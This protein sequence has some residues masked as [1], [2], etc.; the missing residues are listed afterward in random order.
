MF[1]GLGLR[2]GGLTRVANNTL[3]GEWENQSRIFW[4]DITTLWE[5]LTT[6]IGTFK[7]W[8]EQTKEYWQL[9]NTIDWNNW[10]ETQGSLAMIEENTL[11]NWDAI[12]I[13]WEN[14][15]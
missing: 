5:T 4:E 2:L 8:N 13:N 15:E 6:V 3:S 12:S 7:H 9:E 1:I 14:F 11:I 10:Y